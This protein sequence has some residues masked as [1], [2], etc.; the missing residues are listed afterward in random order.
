MRRLLLPLVL[1]G[2]A[3]PAAAQVQ[4]CVDARGK[5]VYQDEPC[6]EASVA[7]RAVDVTDP[8]QAG[9]RRAAPARPA[10]AAAEGAQPEAADDAGVGASALRGEWR[11]LAAFGVTSNGRRLA[12]ARGNATLVLQL[13]PDGSL[14]GFVDG[15]GCRLAG[16]FR[17]L[18][19]PAAASL[20]LQLT[21][22]RDTR[23]NRSYDGYLLVKAGEREAGLA[24]HALL[25]PRQRP[26]TQANIDARLRR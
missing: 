2:L 20:K 12:D 7:S 11:G 10:S 16:S 5:V 8:V 14:G 3:L 15:S 6:A 23:F 22:C 26:V 4:R 24:L 9:G 19:S 1:V 17:R 13:R 25:E 21:Q 18:G